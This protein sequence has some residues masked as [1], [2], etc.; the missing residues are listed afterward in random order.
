MVPETVRTTL[1]DWT[2]GSTSPLTLGQKTKKP[3]GWYRSIL[4]GLFP[5]PQGRMVK[6]LTLGR[7]ISLGDVTQNIIFVLWRTTWWALYKCEFLFS[8]IPSLSWLILTT[9]S[10]DS[11]PSWAGLLCSVRRVAH[12]LCSAPFYAHKCPPT[13]RTASHTPPLQGLTEVLPLFL[14]I[15]THTDL[16]LIVLP[17]SAWKFKLG[18]RITELEK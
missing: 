17:A 7:V 6:D 18:G 14:I 2:L 13:S 5:L 11:A 4:E 8:S 15:P 10:P 3:H 9:P 16:C 12:A 1:G